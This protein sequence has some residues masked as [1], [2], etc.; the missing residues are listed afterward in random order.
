MERAEAGALGCD[1][2]LTIGTTL[3][4]YP[5]AAVVPAAKRNGA[6]V[7]I[8]NGDPTELDELADE[9]LAAGSARSCRA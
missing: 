2:M 3:A 8:V 6:R 5:A 7:V 1:L 9:L 4:V